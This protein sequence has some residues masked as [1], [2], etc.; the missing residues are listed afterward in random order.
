[1]GGPKQARRSK[2]G[3]SDFGPNYYQYF[4]TQPTIIKKALNL[5]LVSNQESEKWGNLAHNSVLTRF[6]E[7]IIFGL[8]SKISQP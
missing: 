8:V 2:I 7:K 6:L 5:L 4:K 3:L 1:M